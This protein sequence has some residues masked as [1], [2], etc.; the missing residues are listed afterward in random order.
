MSP[1]YE[2]GLLSV[3]K[4]VKRASKGGTTMKRYKNPYPGLLID[5]VSGIEVPDI[6]HKIWAEGYNAG[7]RDRQVIKS[8]I[9]APNGMVLVFDGKGEQIPEYQGRY[10]K[11]KPRIL[12]DAPPS[13]EFGYA[14]DN[15]T[16]LKTVPREGW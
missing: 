2:R 13:A 15:E 1:S 7:K 3:R 9:K 4:M 10:E 11:V 6:R 8:V 12:K 14:F 16:Q 5:E